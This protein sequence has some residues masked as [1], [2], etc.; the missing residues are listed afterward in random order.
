MHNADVTQNSLTALTFCAHSTSLSN[1]LLPLIF[2]Y[3]YSFP[4]MLYS[5]PWVA[6]GLIHSAIHIKGSPRST[7]GSIGGF[8]PLQ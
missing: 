3:L 1:S 5:F 2:P 8:Y 4:E 6:F 7:H